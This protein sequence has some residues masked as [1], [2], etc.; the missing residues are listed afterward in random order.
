M[1]INGKKIDVG[2]VTVN[3]IN[4]RKRDDEIDERDKEFARLQ[5]HDTVEAMAKE[6]PVFETDIDG[7]E[8]EPPAKPKTIRNKPKVATEA[9]A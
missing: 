9:F 4:A 8:N 2:G 7:C 3:I 1:E 5:G 6:V